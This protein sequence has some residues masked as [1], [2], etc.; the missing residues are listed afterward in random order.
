MAQASGNFARF[1]VW[2]NLHIG[3]YDTSAFEGADWLDGGI[4]DDGSPR[5]SSGDAADG[6]S[7]T[8]PSGDSIDGGAFTMRDFAVIS[9][10]SSRTLVTDDVVVTGVRV[11]ASD[12]EGDGSDLQ[13]G[14]AALYGEEGYVLSIEGNPLVKF[15]KAAEAASRIGARVVGMRFRPFDASCIGDP[16]V[17]AGDPVIVV[18]SLGREYRSFVTSYTYKAGA[19]AS[20]ACSAETPRRNSA[21][22]ASA[23]TK[24]Y[25]A[26]RNAVK[27]ERTEREK[28]VRDLNVKLAEGTGL[29]STTKTM[30]DGSTVYYLHDRPTLA[31]SKIVWEMNANGLGIST[32]GGK[33]YTVGLDVSGNAILNKVY[34]IGIDADYVTAGALTVVKGN[35][36]VFEADVD[37]GGLYIDARNGNARVLYVNTDTGE[38]EINA[39]GVLVNTRKAFADDKSAVTISSGVVTFNSNTFVVNSTNFSVTANGTITAKAG[40]IG[41]FSINS[42]SIYS[43]DITL[44]AN[45][46]YTDLHDPRQERPVRQVRGRAVHRLDRAQRPQRLPGLVRAALQPG[47]RRRLVHGMGLREGQGAAPR[48]GAV[49][50]ERDRQPEHAQGQRDPRGRRL[51]AEPHRDGSVDRPRHG[52]GRGRADGDHRVLL[53]PVRGLRRD[54]E[55]LLHELLAGVQK[56]DAGQGVAAGME[57]IGGAM[58]FEDYEPP[59]EGK[60]PEGGKV[61]TPGKVDAADPAAKLDEI[62]AKLDAILAM[63]RKGDGNA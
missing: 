10:T 1:D 29:Y 40:T 34:A 38:V 30:G 39:S 31:G 60:P 22:G 9:N 58:A 53:P 7:F 47:L 25:V 61:V 14:E 51:R 4:L 35:R 59:A 55:R 43:S 21:G 23:A 18:D 54:P 19:Y 28:A 8:W 6:G 45:G 36:K 17:E 49:L 37:T 3:W 2:G 42:T 50:L 32:D 24:A 57:R 46:L 63:M 12:E 16:T 11:K 52:R 62:D 20:A 15:G 13:D 27:A 33:T 41:G 48:A 44:N 5:Y 56:R 26:A